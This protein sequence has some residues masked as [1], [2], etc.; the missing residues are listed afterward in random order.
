MH[1]IKVQEKEVCSIKVQIFD[2]EC[3]LFIQERTIINADFD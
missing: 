2:A 3:P 1:I